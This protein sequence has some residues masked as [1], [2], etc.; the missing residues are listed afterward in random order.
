MNAQVRSNATLVPV[1]ILGAQAAAFVI[2]KPLLERCSSREFN[3]YELLVATAA[4]LPIAPAAVSQ[5]IAAPQYALAA[6]LYVAVGSTIVAYG[7]WGVALREM[8]AS[9]AASFLYLL[10]A[11]AIGIAW[12]WLGEFLTIPAL[13]GGLVALVGVALTNR[14]RRATI[15]LGE[16]T[17]LPTRRWSG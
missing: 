2:Q 4:L 3:M 7:L 5:V 6:A 17:A 14:R 8:S 13:L 9:Q 16:S 11:I 1:A 10:P 15:D 12:V